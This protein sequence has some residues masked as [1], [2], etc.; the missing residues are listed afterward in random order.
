MKKILIIFSLFICL[1]SC[2]KNE[3]SPLVYND[4]HALIDDI[5]GMYIATFY[6]EMHNGTYDRQGTSYTGNIN[7]KKQSGGTYSLD[8]VCDDND[9]RL[10][11]EGIEPYAY[12]NHSYDVSL[13]HHDLPDNYEKIDE[14]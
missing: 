13:S 8:I 3:D 1:S 10:R 5:E 4:T 12:S 9:L 2:N 14:L 6:N 11:F 7:V